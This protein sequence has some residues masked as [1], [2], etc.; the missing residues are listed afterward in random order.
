MPMKREEFDEIVKGRLTI[1]Q[2]ILIKGGA[3]YASDSNRLS[4]FENL[5]SR[6]IRVTNG[7]T[8]EDVCLIFMQ[9]H[10]DGIYTYINTKQEQRDSI[11]G[12]ITDAINYLLILECILRADSG[13]VIPK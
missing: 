11:F 6:L 8:P 1:V 7:I 2:D 9:K 12:R 5:A 4:N 13:K 3:E 10:I